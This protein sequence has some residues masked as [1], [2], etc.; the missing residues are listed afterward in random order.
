MRHQL[1]EVELHVDAGLGRAEPVNDW[2][3]RLQ[4]EVLRGVVDSKGP[5]PDGGE[6]I[7]LLFGGDRRL[8]LHALASPEGLAMGRPVADLDAQLYPLPAR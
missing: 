8:G 1:G 6:Q 3:R 5:D 4:G 7:T 2:S